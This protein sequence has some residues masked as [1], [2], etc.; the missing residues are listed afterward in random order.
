MAQKCLA[1]KIAIVTL[2]CGS[3]CVNQ[4]ILAQTRQPEQVPPPSG[5]PTSEGPQKG[6]DEPE[7]NVTHLPFALT[8]DFGKLKPGTT[9]K[10]EVEIVNN[11]C[12]LLRITSIRE[13][14]CREHGMIVGSTKDELKLGEKANIYVTWEGGY[15]VGPKTK[16]IYVNMDDGETL[17]CVRIFV[18]VDCQAEQP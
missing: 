9:V 6:S 17:T 16:E 13:S 18:S 5:K 15:F 4:A 7:R 2:L 14:G 11:S 12:P 10:H 3:V 8:H 1:T